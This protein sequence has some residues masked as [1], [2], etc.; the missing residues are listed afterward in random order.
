MKQQPEIKRHPDGTRYV[1][2][3]MGINRVTGKV[4]RPYKSFPPTMSDEDVRKEADEWARGLAPYAERH[5]GYRLSEVMESYIKASEKRG[6][7]M[8]NTVRTYR[9]LLRH[10]APLAGMDVRE[11]KAHDIDALYEDLLD[12][13]GGDGRGLGLETVAMLH[14]L[15]A[16]AFRWMVRNGLIDSSPM[17]DAEKPKPKPKE[18]PV[19][20]RDQIAAL[21]AAIA[22]RLGDTGADG[23]AAFAAW[24]GLNMGL[25]V[26]EACA[27]KVDDCRLWV[28]DMRIHGTVVETGGAPRLQGWTKGK[29]SRTISIPSAGVDVVAHRIETVQAIARRNPSGS[30]LVTVDGSLMRP[31]MVSRAV[32]ALMRRAGAPDG[33]SFHTLRHTHATGLLAA[34]EDIETVSKRLGHASPATTLRIYAHAVP[35]KNQ[36]A[37]DAFQAFMRG[38]R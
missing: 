10:T 9:S 3:Y 34:G 35:D 12:A 26:G 29:R 7:L 25:R 13:D 22:E 27:V 4:W 23:A 5:I 1:Q 2:P 20:S 28:P 37:A 15:L 17:N 38:E 19:L 8:P 31:T 32:S 24:L 14:A 30:P 6:K 33:S 11:I 36:K 18:A 16:R 21:D